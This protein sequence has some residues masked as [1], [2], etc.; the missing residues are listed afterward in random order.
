VKWAEMNPYFQTNLPMLKGAIVTAGLDT[1]GV[2]SSVTW[3]WDE[4]NMQA[5]MS[6]A[7]PV[8]GDLAPEGYTNHKQMGG[9]YLTTDY[10]G[11]NEGLGDA[12]DAIHE[13]LNANGYDFGGPV[14]EEHVTGPGKE[15][16]PAKWLT[17]IFYPVVKKATE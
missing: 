10:Y 17:K 16:D 1:T 8:K 15:S 7:I 13:Y 5:D 9:T 3:N 11:S 12:H 6:V 2:P 14:V 4:E